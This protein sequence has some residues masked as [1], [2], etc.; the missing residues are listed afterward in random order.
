MRH[1]LHGWKDSHITLPRGRDRTDELELAVDLFLCVVP[2]LRFDSLDL[3]RE[4]LL[5][6]P[7]KMGLKRIGA[8]TY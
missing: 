6:G 8:C 4:F 7:G 5:R 1:V 3:R 2:L